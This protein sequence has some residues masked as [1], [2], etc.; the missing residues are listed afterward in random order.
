MFLLTLIVH[1]TANKNLQTFNSGAGKTTLLE[2]LTFRSKGNLKVDGEI[3]INGNKVDSQKMSIVSCFVQQFDLFFET[4]TVKEHINF[5]VKS[6][7]SCLLMVRMKK[8]R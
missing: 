6:L 3:K 4:M 2:A 7:Q 5:Q 1:F 8:I